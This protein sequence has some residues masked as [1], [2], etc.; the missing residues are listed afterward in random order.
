MLEYNSLR[1]NIVKRNFLEKFLEKVSDFPVWIKEILY[2][3]LA[4]EVDPENN[5]SYEFATFK[6]A[7]TYKGKCELDYKKSNFDSNIYNILDYCDKNASISEIALNTY[8]SMEEIAGYFLFGVDEGYIQIPDKSQILNI[9]GLLAGKFKMG[10]YFVQ[11]GS[12]SEEQLDSA[13]TGY[14]HRTKK[15]KKFGQV[16]V[17]MGLISKEQLDK[18]LLIKDEAKKRFILDHHEIPKIKEEYTNKAD[19]YEKQI[20]DLKKENAQLRMQLKHLLT[21]V[22]N[23]D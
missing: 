2:V 20:E 13:I 6:P 9:A 8:M 21:M 18:I 23:N 11:D 4:Q 22:R 19:E 16:L 12:I 1:E 10:E 5:L 14:E 15:S 3:N 7:L 17:D